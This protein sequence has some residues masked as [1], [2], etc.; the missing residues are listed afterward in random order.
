[1]QKIIDV[2]GSLNYITQEKGILFR[3][4][5]SAEPFSSEIFKIP[6]PQYQYNYVALTQGVEQA[7]VLAN[8]FKNLILAGD[9]IPPLEG[10]LHDLRN[11]VKTHNDLTWE[12]MIVP[13]TVLSDTSKYNK[14]T[15]KGMLKK[16]RN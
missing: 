2:Y 15:K 9:D 6:F 3:A 8:T 10:H 7:E 16:E 13:E 11:L 1:M 12:T 4:F 14:Y 5:A